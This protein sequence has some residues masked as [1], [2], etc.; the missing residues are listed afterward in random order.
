[1]I[2]LIAFILEILPVTSTHSFK[3]TV[4]ANSSL[5]SIK[6]V[7][8]MWLFKELV[9]TVVSSTKLRKIV[10]TKSIEFLIQKILQ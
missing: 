1:M 9:V 6:D 3:Y 7:L 5:I 2:N 8:Q 4:M 10:L